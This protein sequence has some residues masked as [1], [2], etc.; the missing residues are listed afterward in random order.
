MLALLPRGRSRS[1]T[2]VGLRALYEIDSLW[3]SNV[4]SV[5]GETPCLESTDLVVEQ[6]P[7]HD[8]QPE[9]LSRSE[10]GT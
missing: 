6:V 5:K 1:N 3:E 9:S 2:G 7:Y 10:K 8:M 4:S